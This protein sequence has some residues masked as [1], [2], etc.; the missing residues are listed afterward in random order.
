M[1]FITGLPEVYRPSD[2]E[3]ELVSEEGGYYCVKDALGVL[4]RIPKHRWTVIKRE[5][6]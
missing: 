4:W 6:M 3:G 5:M 1:R 2:V